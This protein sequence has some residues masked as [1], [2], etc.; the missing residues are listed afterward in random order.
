MRYDLPRPSV[1]GHPYD[2]SFS[3][4]KTAVVNIVHNAE[5]RGDELDKPSLAAALA[6]AVSDTLVS[7]VM[8]A[9]DECGHGK[10]ALAGGVAANSRIRAD[11]IKAAETR[12]KELYIPPIALCGDNAAMIGC[13]GYYEYMAGV[14]AGM[15]LNAYATMDAGLL[16]T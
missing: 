9:A 6:E 4:L 13:Q 10:I 16:V 11:F 14:R 2:M 15:D 7:R 8:A 1:E 3:G 12:G 5:Q